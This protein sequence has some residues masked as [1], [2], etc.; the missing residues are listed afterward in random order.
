[1]SPTVSEIGSLNC[2]PWP[3]LPVTLCWN[4]NSTASA[5]WELSWCHH[6]PPGSITT[7]WQT[8]KLDPCWTWALLSYVVC[9]SVIPLVLTNRTQG[10]RR[11]W[12]L[13]QTARI[14]ISIIVLGPDSLG[15][16]ERIKRLVLCMLQPSFYSLWLFGFAHFIKMEK[17]AL[18][19][20]RCISTFFRSDG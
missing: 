13:L 4:R 6:R 8:R 11:Q 2:S 20:N 9:L 7:H 16:R 15:T 3:L 19:K 17:R 14:S 5:C 10:R 18:S 12:Q 1:M